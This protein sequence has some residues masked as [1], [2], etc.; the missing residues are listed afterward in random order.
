MLWTL[1]IADIT[2]GYDC[3]FILTFM[4]KLDY[5]SIRIAL[6]ILNNH[7]AIINTPSPWFLS[8]K[9]K[10]KQFFVVD[11]IIKCAQLC[12]QNWGFFIIHVFWYLLNF[13]LCNFDINVSLSWWKLAQ[14]DISAQKLREFFFVLDIALWTHF[15]LTV[16]T[17]LTKLWKEHD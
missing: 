11:I 17:K 16:M 9:T 14:Q 12:L 7:W 6:F 13:L 3:S 10:F 4:T 8:E 2:C 5:A 15:P 1:L